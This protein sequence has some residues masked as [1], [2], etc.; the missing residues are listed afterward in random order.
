MRK[1]ILTALLCF[2]G[3]IAQLH[4]QDTSFSQRF[5]ILYGGL[6]RTYMS[7]NTLYDRALEFSSKDYFN[8][9]FDTAITYDNWRQIYLEY[10]NACYDTTDFLPIDT[11]F[12]RAWAKSRK[13]TIPLGL[14]FFRYDY[15]KDYAVDS[16]LIYFDSLNNHY[17]DV[18]NRTENPY[19]QDTVFTVAALS[20]IISDNSTPLLFRIYNPNK[21]IYYLT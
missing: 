8:G 1:L 15:L 6:N 17:T 19:G 13:D 16:N 21:E 14:L 5:S 18:T 10:R 2:C 11:I 12:N 7:T 4:A 9:R 3:Y 20:P